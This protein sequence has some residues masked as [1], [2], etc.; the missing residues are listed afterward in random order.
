L[1]ALVQGTGSMKRSDAKALSNSAGLKGAAL[2]AAIDALIAQG[3][4]VLTEAAPTKQVITL[5]PRAYMELK[6]SLAELVVR[7]QHTHT[8]PRCIA[9]RGYFCVP[10]TVLY[11]LRRC[12]MPNATC[13]KDYVCRVCDV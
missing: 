5:G 6:T 13:A 9:M 10:E 7:F 11:W 3:M 1:E 8:P 12:R 2:D 4:L